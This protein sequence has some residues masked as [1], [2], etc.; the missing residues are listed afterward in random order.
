MP[1]CYL[2]H[3][4]DLLHGVLCLSESTHDIDPACLARVLLDCRILF[5]VS[6]SDILASAGSSIYIESHE[7]VMLLGFLLACSPCS[8]ELVSS[9]RLTFS[10]PIVN[11]PCVCLLALAKDSSFLTGSS[12]ATLMPNLTLPFVYSWPGYDCQSRLQRCDQASSST[13]RR[14]SCRPAEPPRSDSV[15]CPSPLVCLRRIARNLIS[16]SVD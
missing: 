10:S 11:F 9:I 1:F 7:N 4:L 15:P 6:R 3:V 13:V 16:M 14:L 5:R 8:R 12:C 2:Q